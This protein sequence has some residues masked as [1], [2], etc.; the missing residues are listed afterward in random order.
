MTY[1]DVSLADLGYKESVDVWVVFCDPDHESRVGTP[2]RAWQFLK[3]GFRHLE[4]WKRMSTGFWIR[5]DP[6]IE[7]IGVSVY[8]RP[9]WQILQKQNPTCLRV[10]RVIKKGRWRVRFNVGPAS[11]VEI[12]KAFLGVPNFFVRTP[13]QL[14]NFLR[15]ENCEKAKET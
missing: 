7:L 3:E 14:Y 5:C 15:K 11:C 4:I 10:R 9:P 2:S 8:D 6:S 12:A 1:D 13:F